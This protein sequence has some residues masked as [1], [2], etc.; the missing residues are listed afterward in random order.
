MNWPESTVHHV[1]V[2]LSG[3]QNTSL[4]LNSL[5]RKVSKFGEISIFSI[6]DSVP[7]ISMVLP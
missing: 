1:C 3:E 5:W 2:P 7:D 4:Y 6:M